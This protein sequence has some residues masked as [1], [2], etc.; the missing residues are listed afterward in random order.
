M[1]KPKFKQPSLTFTQEL[2]Q[3]INQYFEQ[4]KVEKT[5]N[6]EL[7]FKAIVLVGTLI[8]MYICLVIF[9]HSGWLGITECVI[10]SVAG[11]GIGFNVMHDGGH[12][13][14]SKYSWVNK[15][16]SVSLDV[17][18]ASSYLW[19]TKHNV[20]HHTYTN[21]EGVDDDIEPG[22]FLRFHNSQKK[23]GFHKYQYLYF[24][25]LYALLYF[26]WVFQMDMVKYFKG[27]IGRIDFPKMK[28]KDHLAYWGWKL[29]YVTAF[30]AIPIYR[31]GI[32]NWA[33]GYAT[34][35]ACT[36]VLISIVFQLAHTVEHTN[37]VQIKGTDPGIIEDEWTKHQ[38]RT[39][40]NFATSNKI[41]NWFTGGLNFQ[42]VHHLFP[43]ISHVHYPAINDIIK[44]V[45][46]KHELAYIEYKNTRT[47][48]ISH[49]NFLKQ[50]G[51][52]AA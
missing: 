20:I 37:M 31:V 48:I 26:F 49:I 44:K 12:G 13:S 28:L 30:V 43:K 35:C 14:F 27:K 22:I 25:F 40:A 36:G 4:N 50:M 45:C 46:A 15:L 9:K 6:W 33:I 8:A 51:G 19:N 29:F 2:K 10:L 5:G 52:A 1:T 24:W 16:A 3:N 34:F 11:S 17:L 7:F 21:I 47:A 23:Y 32:G 42:V 18:G 39:T 41:V 38:I